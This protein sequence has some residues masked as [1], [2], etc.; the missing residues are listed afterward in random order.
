MAWPI[1]G[2][3]ASPGMAPGRRLL[4]WGDQGQDDYFRNQSPHAAAAF[5]GCDRY[6]PGGGAVGVP[7]S[8]P[9][10]PAFLLT[11]LEQ[12]RRERPEPI[13][14]LA[15]GITDLRLYRVTVE[16]AGVAVRLSSRR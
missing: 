11:M 16:N 13:A 14:S 4:L 7:G 5:L 1:P 12:V 10:D 9:Q 2:S 15:A 3:A 6:T 8:G